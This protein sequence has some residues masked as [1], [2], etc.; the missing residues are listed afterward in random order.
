MFIPNCSHL[1]LHINRALTVALL[2]AS[3]L[4][5]VPV[6]SAQP[7]VLN[8]TGNTLSRLAE[9]DASTQALDEQIT[10]AQDALN[11]RRAEFA[12]AARTANA[13]RAAAATK[14]AEAEGL[15]QQADGVVAAAFS[16]AR[17]A[18]LSAVLISSSPQDLL[19]KMTALD[20]LGKDTSTR[21]GGATAAQDV[22]EQSAADAATARDAAA[23]SEQD[24]L[25]VQQDVVTR[26]AE[27]QAQTAEATEL[28]GQLTAEQSAEQS[29]ANAATARDAAARSEQDALGGQQDVVTRRAELQAQTKSTKPAAAPGQTAQLAM[30]QRASEQRASRAAI[31]RNALFAQPTVGQLT[32]PFG[33]RGGGQ[34]QGV[35]IANAI[36]TP[37]VSIADGV[38]IDAGPA[39]GFGLWVRVRHDDGTVTVYGHIDTF[40]VA[41]GT[42]V[43][44][45]QQIATIGNRGES[46][47]PHLHLEVI[48]PGGQK[49]DPQRWLADRGITV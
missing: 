41:V 47:G 13:A 12:T 16:G 1:Q 33:A 35:D 49:V 42:R 23:R 15:R 34:H 26:R 17:T 20:L 7:A 22:A 4:A 45:G 30:S 8:D 9:L 24:A 25:G 27:L 32:S 3:G 44:A 29:A 10:T 40:L 46:T 36:G 37:I 5:L 6:A 14:G 43:S 11:G 39:A 48:T 19:D 31:V 21:L 2:A 28:L 38:V 18:R